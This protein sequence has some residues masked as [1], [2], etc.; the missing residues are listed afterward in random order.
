MTV[1]K[2]TTISS[3]EWRAQFPVLVLAIESLVRHA[4]Y[5][6]LRAAYGDDLAYQ[7]WLETETEL[8]DGVRH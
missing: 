5:K 7:W 8:R 6:S 2:T 1:V 4:W 3:D